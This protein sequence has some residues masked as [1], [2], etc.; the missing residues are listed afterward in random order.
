MA[1]EGP[2]I[3]DL[4]NDVEVIEDLFMDVRLLANHAEPGQGFPIEFQWYAE[5]TPETDMG[6]RLRWRLQQTG[7]VLGEQ[8]LRL[9]PG[10][11][12][13]RW[14]DDERLRNLAEVRPPLDL[15]AASYWLEIGMTDPASLAVRKPFQVT[16]SSRI[17]APPP[18]Q[19]P[20]GAHFGERLLLHGVIEPLQIAPRAG[21][22]VAFTLV[23]Q[24]IS[25]M[26][27]DYT[28][29][30]QWLDSEGKLVSQADLPLPRGS[31]N[32]LRDQVELQ[33]VFVDAPPLP[34][35]YRLVAAVYDA[36]SPDFTRLLTPE[37]SDLVDLGIVTVQP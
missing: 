33:T 13:S 34:G 3:V 28:T 16:G 26:G 21:E 15:P 20:I 32:W 31:S 10:Q 22:Q 27:A 24:A 14:P 5:D 29:T 18:F 11:P 17:F 4:E 25:R 6:V 37:G 35:D 1:A 36:A 8:I 30:V 12:T 2:D 7:E 19:T 23:W 9:S